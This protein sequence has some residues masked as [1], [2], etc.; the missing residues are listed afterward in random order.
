[1]RGEDHVRDALQRRDELVVALLRLLGEHVDSGAGDVTR[2]ERVGQ[3]VVVDEMTAA[4]VEEQ[5]TTR[6][7]REFASTDHV[8][9]GG[10]PIN[11]ERDGLT[12]AQQLVER[13]DLAGVAQRET[14]GHVVEVDA[15]AHRLGEHGKLGT[16][17]AVADDA[18]CASTDLMG[19]DRALLP[20]PVVHVA[21]LV[22]EAARE[23]NEFADGQLDDG[24]RVRVGGIEGCDPRL[25]GSV[26]IDLV[27]SDAERADRTQLRRFRDDACREVGRRSDAQVVDA[28]ERFDEIV[29]GERGRTCL[30]LEPASREHLFGVGMDVFEQ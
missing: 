5:R 19:A 18:E 9:I 15:H 7:Q 2:L 8:H 26:E 20:Q 10:A 4:Q 23:G 27:R 12:L 3:R 24:T 13:V 16:D 6:H 17:V 25:R 22:C 21:I 11:V 1:M 29:L 30:D 28:L 14:V